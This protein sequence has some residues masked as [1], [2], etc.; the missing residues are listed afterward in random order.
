M[1]SSRIHQHPQS[2]FT[3]H[4]VFQLRLYSSPPVTISLLYLP[5]PHIKCLNFMHGTSSLCAHQRKWY[6]KKHTYSCFHSMNNDEAHPHHNC[7]HMHIQFHLHTR[8][9][10]TVS[11]ILWNVLLAVTENCLLLI[12]I[13]TLE[14]TDKSFHSYIAIEEWLLRVCFTLKTKVIG[15]L[16][17]MGTV[18][19]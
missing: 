6:F 7:L 3:D 8:M 16:N 9:P 17:L 1:R 2:C 4:F 13:L 15:S 12:I 5:I 14:D 11:I 19:L 18:L 10:N